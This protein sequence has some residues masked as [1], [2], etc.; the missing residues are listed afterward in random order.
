MDSDEIVK[1]CE[2]MNLDD[3]DGPVV[4]LDKKL[5]ESDKKD[6]DLCLI[7]KVLGNKPVNIEGLSEVVGQLWHTPTK[8]RVKAFG[9]FNQ[10]SFWF[11]NKDD[12]QRVYFGEKCAHFFGGLIGPVEDTDLSSPMMRVRVKIDVTKPLMRGLQVFAP[13]V[14]R[15]VS[16]AFQYEY[17]PEFCFRCGA[18]GHKINECLVETDSDDE[19]GGEL[20]YGSWLRAFDLK[21]WRRE[22]RS[23]SGGGSPR[24]GAL[25]EMEI[26]REYHGRQSALVAIQGVDAEVD[27]DVLAGRISNK[28]LL[29]K[30]SVTEL[31]PIPL[32]KEYTISPPNPNSGTKK[33]KQKVGDDGE[34]VRLVDLIPGTS[35]P[36]SKGL[37][38]GKKW[39]RVTRAS[40]KKKSPKKTSVPGLHGGS[41]RAVPKSSKLLRLVKSTKSPRR[42]R[43]ALQRE[44]G[45]GSNNN[46]TLTAGSKRHLEFDEFTGDRAKRGRQYPTDVPAVAQNLLAPPAEQ[47]HQSR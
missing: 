35:G 43:L 19:N 29:T 16:L 11:A 42:D 47:E 24:V 12:Q 14:M 45:P 2:C 17:L 5:Y 4:Y 13:R 26:S 25:E 8:V 28:D 3:R 32:N 41:L 31:T 40:P 6:M 23:K 34:E 36:T 20:R 37:L 39:K 21:Q 9:S 7:G 44:G 18:I 10:F 30:Q 38:A 1:L 15:E 27:K 33:G 22:R 46:T